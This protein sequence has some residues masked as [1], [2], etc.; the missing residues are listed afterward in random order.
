MTEFIPPLFKKFG[1]GVKDLFTEQFE[2]KKYAKV[3]TSTSSGVALETTGEAL[4][5][6]FAGNLKSSYKQADIGT[7]E[8]ELN[9]SGA[10]KFTVKADKLTK[11]LT[12]K[13]SV[14][15][16]PVGKLEVDFAQEF[17]SASFGVDASKDTTAVEGGASVGFDGLSVGGAVKYDIVGQNLADYNSGVE[18]TQ[19]DFTATVKTTN[20]ADRVQAAYLHKVSGDLTLGGLFGYDIVTGKRLLTFGS[21]YKLDADRSTKVKVDTDGILSAVL[22]NRVPKSRAKIVLSSEFNLRNQ[23]ATPEKVGV[24][25][26]FGDD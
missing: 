4:K 2:Y 7:F 19:P 9:T 8:T 26:I 14:D 5:G 15:E 12:V 1:Q 3:K 18:Y 24:G 21:N 13:A 20:Q 23:S 17:Y 22:E 11:G 10:A 16:K 6:D 25:I